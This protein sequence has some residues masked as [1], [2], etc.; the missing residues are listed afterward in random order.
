MN[1]KFYT[2]LPPEAHDIRQKVFVDEQGFKYEF[3]TI[4]TTATHLIIFNDDEA[5]ATARLFS[6][7]SEEEFIVGRIAVL[8]EYRN[9]HIGAKMMKIL[10]T[11]IKEL[12]GKTIALS[13]QCRVRPFYEKQGYEAQG[14]P[15]LE[16]LCKHIKMAKP[17][18]S[19]K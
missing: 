9:K 11:K 5:I 19:T 16:G 3:D 12:G 6:G 2:A 10:Q 18:E 15:Y 17:L 4:D 1:Y 7:K 13:A 14:Q 8:P